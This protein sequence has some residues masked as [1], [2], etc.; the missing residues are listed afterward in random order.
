MTETVDRVKA[1]ST[2]VVSFT[3]SATTGNFSGRVYDALGR[4]LRASAA[5]NG[6]SVDVTIAATE[7]KDGRPGVG[8]V[9][10]KQDDGGTV[11]VY[12]RR[13]RI[14]PGIAADGPEID[15]I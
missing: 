7:W 13:I 5:V 15:Y 8:R 10:L 4:Y 1:G 12:S 3:P 14:I 6:S 9:E 2:A 11:T